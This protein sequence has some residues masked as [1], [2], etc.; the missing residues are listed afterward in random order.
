MSRRLLLLS[1]LLLTA[2]GGALLPGAGDAVRSPELGPPRLTIVVVAGDD[3]TPVAARVE[4]DGVE[5]PASDG[6]AVVPWP[7]R[8][9]T[10]AAS[11]PGFRAGDVRLE[12]F[13]QAG[14]LEFRLDPVV[15]SGRIT[16]AGIAIEGVEVRLGAAVDIT[17]GEGSYQ[18]ERA[19]PGTIALSR[20][21]WEP[22]TFPWDG[23]IDRL[24]LSLRPLRLRGVRVAADVAG[25]ERRWA[26]I[27]SLTDVTDLDAIVVD[28]K[29]EQGIVHHDTEVRRA[30]EIGAVEVDYDLDAVVTDL[31]DRGLYAI[32]RIVV[33][34][35]PFL[36]R[37]EP[38]RAVLDG[39]TGDLWLSASGDPWLDPSDPAS[40]EYAVALAGEACARGF[41]EIQFDY[42]SYPFGGDLRDAV[43][44][45]AYTEEV[46]VASITAFLERAVSVL[47]PKGCAVGVDVLAITLESNGDEGIG[48]RPGALSRIVDVLNPM[49]YT[50]NYG[51]GWK[52]FD[53]PG[54]HA[55]EVVG[56]ALRSGLSQRDGPGYLRPWLQTWAL[57]AATIRE[58]Q[59][60]AEDL[61]LGWM[62]W[63]SG[64]SY[65]PEILP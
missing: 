12:R 6:V 33:F 16:D 42:A 17:D 20:R 18:L 64:R 25:D 23:R 43:F 44:D 45:G 60:T 1:V 22:A 2:C 7:G 9:I 41:D 13:P 4:V 37:A 35:D 51:P 61:G 21:A 29:D 10:V 62:L 50:T 56:E 31:H 48:Q 24:D 3:L 36:A 52:G 34:Q 58:L 53:D 38:D 26:E 14:R 55:V 65:D 46:R 15:L 63:G 30:H 28:L 40:Y 11:A 19:V 59:A 5:V 49:V 57:D 47:A 39:R 32:A 54:E 8:P 27:L